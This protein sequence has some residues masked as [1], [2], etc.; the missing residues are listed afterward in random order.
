M[1]IP[2]NLHVYVIFHDKDDGDIKNAIKCS[3]RKPEMEKSEVE[4]T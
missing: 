3:T 4:K 1:E 2:K